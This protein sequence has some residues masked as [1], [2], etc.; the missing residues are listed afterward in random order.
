MIE[1]CDNLEKCLHKGKNKALRPHE[2]P[3]AS[4]SI[5]S[6]TESYREVTESSASDPINRSQAEGLGDDIQACQE[7][8]TLLS[9]NNQENMEEYERMIQLEERLVHKFDT[10]V[11]D[12][13]KTE[14]NKQKYQPLKEEI[15]GHKL[16][17]VFLVLI[18]FGDCI[19]E[20]FERVDI[21]LSDV[22]DFNSTGEEIHDTVD[23][24]SIPTY[25]LINNLI[26]Y[27]HLKAIKEAPETEQKDEEQVIN[28]DTSSQIPDNILYICTSYSLSLKFILPKTNFPIK[29]N[30]G[31]KSENSMVIPKHVMEYIQESYPNLLKIFETASAQAKTDDLTKEHKS[32]EYLRKFQSPHSI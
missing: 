20:L 16:T 30:K 22:L 4:G 21:K 29:T 12:I 5:S 9:S 26:A 3:K 32:E 10:I 18:L 6:E 23:A 7:Y 28:N 1:G 11:R 13:V 14:D 31:N 19:E 25:T 15:Y 24:N 2:K 27:I 8:F 17:F